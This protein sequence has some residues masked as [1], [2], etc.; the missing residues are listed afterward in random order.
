MDCDCIV[1]HRDY[2]AAFLVVTKKK[3]LKI[4]VMGFYIFS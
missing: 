1:K 2:K 4:I 3:N